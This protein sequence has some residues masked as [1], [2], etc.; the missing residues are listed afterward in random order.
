MTH[1]LYDLEDLKPNEFEMY[2]TL[3]FT[4]VY[5]RDQSNA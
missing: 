5:L 2:Y 1:L 3:L 4:E